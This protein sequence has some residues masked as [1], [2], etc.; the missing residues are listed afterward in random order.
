M[1]K[2]N[3]TPEKLANLS[4]TAIAHVGNA[5]Y[6]IARNDV[7]TTEARQAAILEL[8]AAGIAKKPLQSAIRAA[9]VDRYAATRFNLT[10]PTI[11]PE[12][13]TAARAI[14]G[15]PGPNTQSNDRQTADEARVA[16][17]ARQSWSRMLKYC[18]TESTAAKAKRTPRGETAQASKAADK[19]QAGKAADKAQPPRPKTPGDVVRYAAGAAVDLARWMNAQQQRKLTIPANVITLVHD[20]GVAMKAALKAWEAET[21]ASK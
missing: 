20:F 1:P 11:T 15:K 14:L 19:A 2:T 21:Q 12:M 13:V 17:A 6:G 5:A 16:A 9:Y 4:A 7:A 10:A 3:K 8:K 18:G